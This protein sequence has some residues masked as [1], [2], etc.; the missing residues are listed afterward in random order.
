MGTTI[1][2][3]VDISV[4]FENLVNSMREDIEMFKLGIADKK[5]TQMYEAAMNNDQNK[6]CSV[7]R[8][9]STLHFIQKLMKSYIGELG[10]NKCDV[11]TL[12][13]DLD[14]SEIL[15]WAVINDD[16][17]IN[18]DKLWLAEAKVN[19]EFYNYGFTISTTIVEK[20]DNIEVPPHYKKGN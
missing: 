16:D 13:F 14:N 19:S 6:M 17:E 3:T 18:E 2:S 9:S 20:S 4:W 10:S 12:A 15:V 1:E 7:M 5:K 11:L 8:E